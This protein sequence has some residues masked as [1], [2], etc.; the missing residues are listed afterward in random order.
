MNGKKIVVLAAAVALACGGSVEQAGSG[1][2]PSQQG[3]EVAISPLVANVVTGGMIA[4]AA[5]V[6][7]VANTAVAWSVEEGSSG[8]SVSS[9]GL[10]SAPS[11]EGTYHVVVASSADPTR[12][13]RAIVSVTTGSTT[14]AGAG[15]MGSTSLTDYPKTGQVTTGGPIVDIDDG[16]NGRTPAQRFA[17]ALA[18]LSSNNRVIIRNSSNAPVM[19]TGRIT[20]STAWST[21]KEVFAYG[22]QRITLDASNLTSPSPLLFSGANEHWKG[23]EIRNQN[24]ATG[25]WN[26]IV[27]MSL[28]TDIKLEDFWIH[29]NRSGGSSIWINGGT[30][31]TVQDSIAWHNGDG[32]TQSTNAPDGFV[33][34]GDWNG[35]GLM[36]SYVHFVRD[37]II[38]AGDDAVDLW[39]SHH[40]DV[41]DS[42]LV[43]AGQYWNGT[44]AGDGN[45]VKAGGFAGG[46]PY[47]A[48]SANT[49]TGTIAVN[50]L[51]NAFNWKSGTLPQTNMHNTAVGNRGNGF[52]YEVL[53]HVVYDNISA[54]NLGDGWNGNVDP[55]NSKNQNT[56]AASV[57]SRGNSYQ[58]TGG[59]TLAQPFADP[60]NGDLSLPAGS[61]YIGAGTGGST[62][63]ASVIAL[64]L[65]K[66]NWTRR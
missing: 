3:A 57:D 47:T 9:S 14:L 41:V 31:I 17:D 21:K 43:E 54:R 16:L 59:S 33:A 49:I 38:N 56:I 15:W 23:F 52:V 13:A 11:T 50:C 7:G 37:V 46:S 20:R 34:S 30:R 58:V 1:T 5:S 45:G 48:G 22:T 39:Y 4:F 32:V 51:A 25:G 2:G 44:T 18:L 63:G 64:Q 42:V 6:T 8:G 66:D 65:L 12:T 27:A 35:G 53:N 28:A 60:T 29:D 61:P 40:S 19:L 62:L 36:S 55:Y 26:G 24:T 10:Y